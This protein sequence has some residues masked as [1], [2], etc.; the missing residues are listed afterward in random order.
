MRMSCE[1]GK[2]TVASR[3]SRIGIT[4]NEI[5]SRVCE[6]VAVTPI[7]CILL[8]TDNPYVKPARPK[9]FS[10]KQWQQVRNTSLIIPAVAEKLLN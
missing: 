6:A 2:L 9:N 8:E 3:V 4:N 7:E 5:S 1:C 10:K